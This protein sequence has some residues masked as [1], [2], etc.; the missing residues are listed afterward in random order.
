PLQLTVSTLD[1]SI[2]EDDFHYSISSDGFNFTEDLLPIASETKSTIGTFYFKVF[3]NLLPNT[4]YFIKAYGHDHVRNIK[5]LSAQTS[6]Y[7]LAVRPPAPT[8]TPISNEAVKIDVNGGSNSLNTKY[9][10]F[11]ETASDYVQGDGTVGATPVYKTVS[12]WSLVTNTGLDSSVL[13]AYKVRA[14]NGDGVLTNF[15]PIAIARTGDAD[16]PAPPLETGVKEKLPSGNIVNFTGGTEDGYIHNYYKPWPYQNDKNVYNTGSTITVGHSNYDG[17]YYD[18]NNNYYRGYMTFDTSSI[19]V[20]AIITGATINFKVSSLNKNSYAQHSDIDV[21]YATQPTWGTLLDA[22]DWDVGANSG[23]D[24]LNTA[25]VTAGNY[26]S[27]KIPL[28]SI[29]KLGRSEYVLTDP[30]ERDKTRSYMNT[31]KLNIYSSESAGN[32]PYLD[33]SYLTPSAGLQ[34]PTLD[35][36]IADSNRQLTA[37]ITDNASTTE[38]IHFYKGVDPDPTKD[39]KDPIVLNEQPTGTGAQGD[40][41]VSG[42]RDISEYIT[43]YDPN[44]GVIPNFNKLT[45]ASGGILTTSTLKKLEFKAKEV[46]VESGGIIDVSGKG[47]SGGATSGNYTSNPGQGQGGGSNTGGGGYGGAGGDGSAWAGGGT[48]YGLYPDPITFGSGGSS[49]SSSSSVNGAGG[50]GGGAL[51]LKTGS[52]ILNGQI[53]ANGLNGVS[54]NAWSSGG[55]GGSGG[56]V[57]IAV[58]NG[59]S[60]NAG[61]ISA[62]GGNAGG[63]SGAA[64]RGSGGGAGGRI[65]INGVSTGILSISGGSG[66]SST[67]SNYPDGEPGAA[68]EIKSSAYQIASPNSKSFH[69]LSTN[70]KYYIRSRAYDYASGTVSAYSNELSKYTFANEPKK[71]IVSQSSD[72]SIKVILNGLSGNPSQTEYAIFNTT[73]VK[74]VQADGTLANTPDFQTY[75]QWGGQSGTIN[76]GL[77]AN[78]TYSYKAKAKNGDGVDTAWSE[79]ATASTSTLGANNFSAV[80]NYDDIDGHNINLT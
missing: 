32:E 19:P 46:V 22:S 39:T 35:S 58:T 43:G 72:D 14:Q 45:I 3:D 74:Y 18:S 36:L 40:I 67:N 25:T 31:M 16:P 49:G 34:A 48:A 42:Q 27:L 69:G 56:G 53:L 73:L 15:G 1:N 38:E 62:N 76:T 26:Y 79:E 55:A 6:V 4:Q 12:E 65:V 5:T 80:S 37:N 9:A 51:V 64:A 30:N 33:V 61:N 77:K 44:E 75:A 29:N 11:N 8:V 59:I 41:V 23:S 21:K 28:S 63:G 71:P 50:T 52:L 10:I 54:G 13:Y 66:G 20:G 70:T 2:N 47:Y 68:G 78:S 7:T 60:F 17:G 24:K 57:Y